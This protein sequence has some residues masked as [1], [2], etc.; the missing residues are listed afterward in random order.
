MEILYI[1]N[2]QEFKRSIELPEFFVKAYETNML[3][4]IEEYATLMDE[5]EFRDN[6]AGIKQILSNLSQGYIFDD[7]GFST[8]NYEN[9]G[10]RSDGTIIC[11]DIGYVYSLRGQEHLLH[12]P[13]CNA[14]LKYNSNYTGF[15]CQ[16]KGCKKQFSPWDVFRRMDMTQMDIENEVIAQLN[17]VKPPELGEISSAITYKYMGQ[18]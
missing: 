8:K 7:I 17:S 18:F 14:S 1:D 4:L 12:C 6:E 9:W 15:I 10:Y 5:Q 2:Y 3:I 16:N 13:A 11:I